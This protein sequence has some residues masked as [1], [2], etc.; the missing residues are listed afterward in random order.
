VRAVAALLVV[1]CHAGA[2]SGVTFRSGAGIYLARMEVG[3]SVFFVLSG[4]LLYRAFAVRHLIGGEPPALVRFWTRRAGRIFPAYWV[5]LTLVP[6]VIGRALVDDPVDVGVY[7]GL[8]QIYDADRVLGGL[9]QAWSLCTELAFYLFLPIYAMAM[10]RRVRP[11]A[12]QL[13]VEL[14]GIAALYAASVIFRISLLAL[15]VGGYQFTWLPAW[16]D[17]FALGMGLAVASAWMTTTR[18]TPRVLAVAVERPALCL[19]IAAAAFVAVSN[20][21]IPTGLAPLSAY[22]RLMGQ[23][24][25]SLVAVTLVAPAVFSQRGRLPAVL[26]SR[27]LVAIGLV[28]YSMYLWHPAMIDK[29]VDWT[30]GRTLAAEAGP[31]FVLSVALTVAVAAASYVLVERPLAT[32]AEFKRA[33]RPSPP[34]TTPHPPG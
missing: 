33:P 13:R 25:Y 23:F 30:G 34:A 7:Y 6:V 11:L 14:A 10:S 21:G 3:V 32:I 22:Q 4:F 9:Y 18:S 26:T 20:L 31:V 16:L 15:G 24:L 1:F 17:M 8:A 12:S 28:S 27:P 29:A 19:A 2:V 5:A